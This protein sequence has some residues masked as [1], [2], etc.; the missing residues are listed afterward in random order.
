VKETDAT[1]RQAMSQ[2][3]HEI[4]IES[5]QS[6]VNDPF[7]HLNF[8][9]HSKA[10]GTNVNFYSN[11]VVDKLIEENMHEPNLEKRNAASREVQ[12]ILID[13]AV[14]GFLWY[15]N[16][17]RV[18]KTDLYGLEKRWDTFERYYSVYRKA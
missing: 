11:P 17:T 6:W 5:F 18:M 13:E 16:W 4:S 14:W 8:N 2:G 7:Y 15:D 10:K 9:F 12:R 1:F 3:Q